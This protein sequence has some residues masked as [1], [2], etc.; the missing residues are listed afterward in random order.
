VLGHRAVVM[1]ALVRSHMIEVIT[2]IMHL[3]LALTVT[4][5]SRDREHTSGPWC[6]VR[7]EGG[8][9]TVVSLYI[10]LLLLSFLLAIIR[11]AFAVK[12]RRAPRDRLYI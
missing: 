12:H 8:I 9:Y 4:T 5:T 7:G 10:D 3:G 2:P 1:R 11:F 6:S